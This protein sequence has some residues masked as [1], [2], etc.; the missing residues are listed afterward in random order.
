M[1]YGREMPLRSWG[2]E[3]VE[4]VRLCGTYICEIQTR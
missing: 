1:K 3:D 4:V 2:L